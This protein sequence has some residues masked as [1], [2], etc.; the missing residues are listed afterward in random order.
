MTYVLGR[1]GLRDINQRDSEGI[2][3][4]NLNQLARHNAI[5]HDVSLSRRDHAQGDNCTSQKDLVAAIVSSSTD[6]RCISTAD[7]AA[8]RVR[9]LQQ[10]KKDN[11]NLN[12][13]SAHL[14]TTSG[15]VAFFQTMFG[16][17]FPN[18]SVP[19][20]YVKALFE[21]ER[22]PVREGWRKRVWISVGFIESLIQT[23]V[24]RRCVKRISRGER[25]E[26]PRSS[27]RKQ[28]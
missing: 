23:Q 10:Q 27:F 24:L 11:P 25:L 6:G 19:V 4:L 1:F 12:L 28:Q 13:G 5:E 22:L 7:F 8:L 26:H 17:G 9:R 2:K 15:E 14:I 21:E 20:S 3:C 16:V 18:Y